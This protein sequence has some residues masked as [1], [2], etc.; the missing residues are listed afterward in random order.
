MRM[1]LMGAVIAAG[2]AAAETRTIEIENDARFIRCADAANFAICEMI[3]ADAEK[4]HRCVAF[5][6]KEQPI[7]VASGSGN[8]VMYRDVKAAQITDVVCERQR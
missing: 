3:F 4:Y 7:A 8:D 2:S 5:D 6:Q 1:M